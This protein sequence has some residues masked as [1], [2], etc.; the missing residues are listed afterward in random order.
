MVLK[1]SPLPTSKNDTAILTDTPGLSPTPTTS[2]VVTL[3]PYNPSSSSLPPLGSTRASASSNLGDN[4]STSGWQTVNRRRQPH[5]KRD[6]RRLRQLEA[7][8][9]LFVETEPYFD[10]FFTVRFPV[11]NINSDLNVIR[12]EADLHSAVGKPRK[13]VKASRNTLLLEACS[14]SQSDKIRNLRTIADLPVAVSPF[15]HLNTVRGIVR[16]RAMSQCTQE[17]LLERLTEQRVTEI[18]RLKTRRDGE[19]VDLDTYILTF[20]ASTLPR[21]VK[22]SDWHTELVDEYVD[23]PR[24]CFRCQKFGH[25]AKYCRQ[26]QDT[27]GHCGTAGHKRDSCNNPV[28]CFHCRAPHNASD[29]TCPKYVI[30]CEVLKTQH[31][32]KTSRIIALDI[33]LTRYPQHSRLYD[34]SPPVAD[35]HPTTPNT[36]MPSL[37]L[38]SVAAICTSSPATSDRSPPVSAGAAASLK[39]PIHTVSSGQ[40]RPISSPCLSNRESPVIDLSVT[41]L[42]SV[43]ASVSVHQPLEGLMDGSDQNATSP[44]TTRSSRVIRDVKPVD[45]RTTSAHSSHRAGTS[46]C[47]DRPRSVSPRRN[48]GSTT[49]K[50]TANTSALPNKKSYSFKRLTP[51]V[52]QTTPEQFKRKLAAS[53][54]SL[55]SSPPSSSSRSKQG[56]KHHPSLT[57]TSSTR[58]PRN[59]IPKR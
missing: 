52:K 48:Q 24:Q 36:L 19:L 51:T 47:T 21:V 25:V 31:S 42:R 37:P 32:E 34:A 54:D 4:S 9:L 12:A 14:K 35:Q 33:V 41:D 59:P 23:R 5:R 20:Q 26:E 2:C 8:N 11:Q 22:L 28:S 30:E 44:K 49:S 39:P 27:C 45:L 3:E 43:L 58:P 18:R 53:N 38:S 15:S 17:E 1:N 6:E 16:S 55:S 29:R 50:T 56:K 13:T 57:K 46:G 10:R 40:S 7:Y